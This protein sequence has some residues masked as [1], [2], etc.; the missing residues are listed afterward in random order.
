M[1]TAKPQL[2]YQKLGGA[3]GLRGL[4]HRF[5][6]LMDELP[7]AWTV[8][9]LYPDDLHASEDRLTAFLSGWLGGPPL[10]APVPGQP[11]S[12]P[13]AHPLDAQAR[14]EWLMCMRL[15][16]AERVADLGF[17]EALMLAFDQMAEHI[18]EEAQWA[19]EAPPL[20]H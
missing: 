6:D 9:R 13:P 19:Q 8:R 10:D 3:P 17:R 20:P 15:A 14:D 2:P 12:K 18:L 11:P 1:V 16:L 4:V 5:F 7:E